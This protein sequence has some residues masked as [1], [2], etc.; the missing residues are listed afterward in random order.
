MAGMAGLEPANAGVK[1]PCLTTWLHPKMGGGAKGRSGRSGP[2]P[3][4]GVGNGART[5]DT[6][7]HNP[8]LC[9][10][11]YTHH[12]QLTLPGR[13]RLIASCCHEPSFAFGEWPIRPLAR[14]KGLEPLA[15][16]LEGSCSIHLSYR[17]ISCALR[18]PHKAAP[19]ALWGKKGQQNERA[20][21]IA[22]SEGCGARPDAGAGDGNRTHATSLEGWDSTIELHPQEDASA[23][24][25][26]GMIP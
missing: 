12:I 15:H 17:R 24:V 16:C 25:S 18:D 10:L 11:S 19:Q 22:G 13:K 9:Q 8:V 2:Q 20:F 26:L 6:R 1:V 3:R 23:N 5:H 7:N 14:L 4:Y 21:G